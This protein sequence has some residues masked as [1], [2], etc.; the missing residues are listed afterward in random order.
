[1]SAP[2][3]GWVL[4]DGGCGFCRRWVVFWA[5]VLRRR[6][7]DVAPLQAP[8]VAERLGLAHEELL[9][10]L[11]LLQPD[12]TLVRGAEAY[13]HA[14]RRIGWAWPIWL[15]SVLPGLRWLFDRGYRTFA[16]HRHRISRSCG[17]QPHAAAA[18]GGPRV[19]LFLFDIAGTV[20]R[21]DD[22]V[23]EAL[24][25]TGREAGLEVEEAWLRTQMGLSK[26]EVFAA[27]LRRAGRP[28]DT[29]PDLAR[30]F[31][32]LLEQVLDEQPPQPQPGAVEAIAALE[33]A[34]VRVG[35]TTGFTRALPHRI[36]TELDWGD[37]LLVPS[38]EV[39]RGRPAPDMVHEAM[40][41]AGVADVSRVGVCGDTPADLRAGHA[42]G[43]GLVVGVCNGTHP[44][45]QLEPHPH[46]HLI[47]D[48]HAL[49]PIVGA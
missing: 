21:D 23:V 37:R 19:Q 45:E 46:T 22:L 10:D 29:A 11:L 16:D 18:S 32:A 4:Y 44:R 38:D 12:G 30:R 34:G 48:L 36:L 31:G 20:M 33:A 7:Y 9:E 40:R 8:W 47:D 5:S 6:G 43:C 27:M 24:G 35:F 15:L 39:E 26:S 42:A 13:R 41:R 49:A 17:L 2:P 28:I 14:L 25:R 3:L 1:V